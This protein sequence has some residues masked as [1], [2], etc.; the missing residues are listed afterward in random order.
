[1]IN[2]SYVLITRIK[3]PYKTNVRLQA[4]KEIKGKSLNFIS[5]RIINEKTKC[6]FKMH[7][8]M[9]L[10]YKWQIIV[11]LLLRDQGSILQKNLRPTNKLLN[12]Y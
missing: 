9:T 10:Y 5:S 2:L 3:D 4:N 11:F 6:I 8:Q 12:A 1:M 7:Q